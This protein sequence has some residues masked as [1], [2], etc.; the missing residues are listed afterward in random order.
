MPVCI[1]N[2]KSDHSGNEIRLAHERINFA[3]LQDFGADASDEKLIVIP[4]RARLRLN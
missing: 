1:E 3:T 4:S 2:L